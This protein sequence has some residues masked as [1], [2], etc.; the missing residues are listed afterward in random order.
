MSLNQS[1]KKNKKSQIKIDDFLDRH[2]KT[3]NFMQNIE[4]VS[5]WMANEIGAT[6]GAMVE[7]LAWGNSE[8]K[9]SLQRCCRRVLSAAANKEERVVFFHEAIPGFTVLTLKKEG[10]GSVNEEKQNGENSV[11]DIIESD[12]EIEERNQAVQSIISAYVNRTGNRVLA[13][14]GKDIILILFPV[15]DLKKNLEEMGFYI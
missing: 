10:W 4:D 6:L 2:E 11:K 15:S 3:K 14:E 9:L 5:L 1:N 8:I 13:I 7:D 12:K